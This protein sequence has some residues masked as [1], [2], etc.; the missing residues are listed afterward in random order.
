MP[1][2]PRPTLAL[3]LGDPAGVGPEIIVGAWM[4][5]VVHEWCRPLV[6][7]H[8]EILRR[9]A[10]LWRTGV[11]VVEI[12]SPAEAEPSLD[13]IP[14][15]SCGED[16]VLAVRPGIL[17]S[18]AGHAAYEAVVRATRLAL[19]G[20]VD[21]I[22]TAPLQKEALHRAGHHYPGHTELLAQLCGVDDFAMMLYLGPNEELPAPHG[23][24]VVH[25]TLHT[26][27]KKVFELLTV[28]EILAKARLADRFMS[29][30][31]QPPAATGIFPVPGS[32]RK[33]TTSR[34]ST[35]KMPV[36]PG[37]EFTL[38]SPLSTL[39]SSRPHIGVC[40]LNPHGGEGGLFGEE[41]QTIIRPAVE[42]GIAEGL[43]LEGPLPTDTLMVAARNG[44][45]DALVA[46]YHDQG[47]IALKLMGMHRAVNVT[48]GLPIIRTSVAHGTAF[49]IAW[50]RQADT[51]SMIEAIRVAARL[52][53]TRHN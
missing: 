38:H 13:V 30:L 1:R 32:T 29:K 48:L 12:Q 5:T 47:H 23:L 25:V 3:T 24:A 46:M 9:A 28:D 37:G 45:F 7:G 22:V 44:R 41:E 53:G 17:D 43:W 20:S 34:Q 51:G 8:P 14:C 26:A 39:H 31:M 18:R 10:G 4:E 40:S 16:D 52:A 11:K 15:L 49:D 35:G 50:R 42:K 19:E 36:P 33:A 6:V 27:L 21:A 2:D